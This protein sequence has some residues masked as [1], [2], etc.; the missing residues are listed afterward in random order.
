M[1]FYSLR[2]PYMVQLIMRDLY[3]PAYFRFE[4]LR[5]HFENLRMHLERK[6][7]NI[8]INREG[9]VRKVIDTMPAFSIM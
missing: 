4:N 9:N 1:T 3:P 8:E 5:M 2:W 6:Q 7:P